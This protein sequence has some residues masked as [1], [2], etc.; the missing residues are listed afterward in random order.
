[1]LTYIYLEPH[2]DAVSRRNHITVL[3][4]FLLIPERADDSVK[5]AGRSHGGPARMQ[6]LV[7][8]ILHSMK[9]FLPETEST[10]R[11]YQAVCN[12]KGPRPVPQV[13]KEKRL[14]NLNVQ[15]C[16]MAAF[17]TGSPVRFFEAGCRYENTVPYCEEQ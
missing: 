13:R 5:F 14:T 1:M 15:T 12:A 8:A 17:P 7:H 16:I 9:F 10:L 2:Q 11:L 6:T 3:G 4:V